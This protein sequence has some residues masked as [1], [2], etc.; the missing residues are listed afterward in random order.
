[1]FLMRESKLKRTPFEKRG[2]DWAPA[3]KSTFSMVSASET[4]VEA[5]ADHGF[6]LGRQC[7]L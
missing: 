5:L 3:P 1:M 2:L 6:E 4:Q 7:F